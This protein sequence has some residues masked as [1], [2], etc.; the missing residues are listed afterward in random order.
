MNKF[1]WGVATS[2]FQIEGHIENDFTQWE[3]EGKF[4]RDGLNPIYHNGS[5]HWLMWEKI[6]NC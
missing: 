6:S 5:N 3:I 4:N 2:A 1:F